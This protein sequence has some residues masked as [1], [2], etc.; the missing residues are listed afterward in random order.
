MS[1]TD[2]SVR[3]PGTD[4][5]EA[6]RPPSAPTDELLTTDEVAAILRVSGRT[7]RRLANAGRIVQLRLSERTIRYPRR[8]VLLLLA[9]QRTPGLVLKVD[10]RTLAD[11][12]MRAAA[13][14]R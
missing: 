8:D 5:P 12:V 9:E 3:P 14:G 1:G 4:A 11:T 7:V 2:A 6:A 10:E 13:E